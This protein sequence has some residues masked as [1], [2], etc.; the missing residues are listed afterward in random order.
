MRT[1][2]IVAKKNIKQCAR[3]KKCVIGETEG[4]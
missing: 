1:A 4:S 2:L 3:V